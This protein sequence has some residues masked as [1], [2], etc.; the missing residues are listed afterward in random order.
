[1]FGLDCLAREVN[2]TLVALSATEI[3]LTGDEA[4]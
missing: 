3:P 1:M 4:G 2:G